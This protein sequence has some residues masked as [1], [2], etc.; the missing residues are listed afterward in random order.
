M[1]HSVSEGLD[2]KLGILIP[3]KFAKRAV[4]RNALK[5]LIRQTSRQSVPIQFKGQLLV[6]LTSPVN[7][8]TFSSR[9]AWSKEISLLLKQWSLR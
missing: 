8:V 5:R 6:R 9:A 1:L 4:D 7:S 2:F 3:K